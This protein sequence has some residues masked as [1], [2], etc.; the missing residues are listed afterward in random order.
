MKREAHPGRKHTH[1]KRNTRYINWHVPLLW[2]QIEQAAK[3]PS[4]GRKMNVAALVTL[5]KRRN[6]DDFSLLSRSTVRGWID[7]PKGKRPRWSSKVVEM[8]EHG[9]L[10]GG[11]G[12]RIGIL[13]SYGLKTTISKSYLQF[14][15]HGYPHVVKAIREKLEALRDGAAPV[16]LVTVRGIFVAT[17]LNLAP[18]IFDI[19]Y[20]DGSKFRCSETFLRKWLRD[21]LAWSIRRPTRAGHKL[22]DN[23]DA[24]CEKALFRIAYSIK[25]E[26]IPAELF[27]NTDQTQMVYAP[28]SGMTWTK[29]GTKQVAVVGDEEKRAVTIVVSIANG[30][31]LLPFQVI[32]KGATNRSCP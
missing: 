24:L 27:V 9:H 11:K 22:P 28:G 7:R 19:T 17:I 18:E 2:S 4:V 20:K 15:K 23:A 25:E 5:L 26:E 13:V 6:P 29:S 12:G 3:H 16:S 1:E 30:G 8:A 31:K 21:T 32:F 10:P 14:V